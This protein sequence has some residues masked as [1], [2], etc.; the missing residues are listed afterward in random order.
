MMKT[1]KFP[2][3]NIYVPVARR[4]TLEQA[5]VDEIV[6]SMLKDGQQTPIKVRADGDRF[7]L[8][9]GLHRLEAAKALGEATIIGY[10]V[11]ARKH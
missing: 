10:R 7:V 3:A 2:V 6:Q 5:R 11:D 8:I 1:E 9:E 4:K